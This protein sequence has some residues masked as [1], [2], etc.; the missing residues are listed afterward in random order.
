MIDLADNR[1]WYAKTNNLTSVLEFDARNMVV[2]HDWNSGS[3]WTVKA[4]VALFNSLAMNSIENEL[5]QIG[6]EVLVC[7]NHTKQGQN[8]AQALE[9]IDHA[10]EQTSGLEAMLNIRNDVYGNAF[11]S[12]N[13]N[14]KNG[15]WTKS[16]EYWAWL[17]DPICTIALHRALLEKKKTQGLVDVSGAH[18]LGTVGESHKQRAVSV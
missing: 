5:A 16:R 6:S 14:L 3:R 12:V 11:N 7:F 4:R 2:P 15:E 1:D 8:V 9:F 17:A 10:L 13:E 18:D